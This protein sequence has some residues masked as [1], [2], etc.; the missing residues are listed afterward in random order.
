METYA[1]ESAVLR[2]RKRAAA[3]GEKDAALVGDAVRCFA[4]DAMDRV[5]ISARRVLAAVDDGDML[6][7]Y[8]AALDRFAARTGVEVAFVHKGQLDDNEDAIKTGL[9]RMLQ[10]CLTNISRHAQA[11]TVD[12]LL[13]ATDLQIEMRIV[14]DG[15]GFAPEAR[16]KRGSFGLFGLGE[17]AVLLGGSVTVESAPQAGTRITVRLPMR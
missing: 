5:E 17:R 6:K 15:C 12:I 9:Y 4:Q 2:A 3:R 16:L 14:D 8:R 7:T 11:K 10:E 1:L 13:I